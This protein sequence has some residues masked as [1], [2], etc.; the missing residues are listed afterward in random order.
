VKRRGTAKVAERVSDVYVMLVSGARREQIVSF[1]RQHWDVR[2]RTVDTYIAK[3]KERLEEE[4]RVRRSVELGK[5]LARLDTQYFKADSRKDHRGA[6]LAE[7]VR[8]KLLRLDEH[9]DDDN[10][11]I[12][13]FLDALEVGGA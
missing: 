13:R 6:V 7:R 5:V 3:A 1:A 4:S 10:D 11:E 9:A 8:I 2:P 12:R